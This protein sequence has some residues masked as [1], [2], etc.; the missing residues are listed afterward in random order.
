[1]SV[2]ELTKDAIIKFAAGFDWTRKM[3][4]WT[5]VIDGKEFPARPLLLAAAGVPPNDPTNSHMA[6]ARLKTLG[7]E[8]RYLGQ[9]A[10]AD[11]ERFDAEFMRM[12]VQYYVCGRWSARQG[13]MPVC[14]NFFHHAV[15]M[16]LKARLS[17]TYTTAELSQRPFAH[18]LLTLWAAF[19]SDVNVDEL[20]EFDPDITMLDRFESLRYP[21]GIVYRGAAIR[22][23]WKPMVPVP[24]LSEALRAHAST[25]PQYEIVVSRIDRLVKRIFEVSSRNPMFFAYD[26]RNQAGEALSYQN[27]EAAFW[28]PSESKSVS[29]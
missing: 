21:E 24:E 20:G 8:T 18:N 16:L 29:Q 13:H 2:D 23:S 25:V 3:P 22:T 19:K 1:M 14:G 28:F 6:V 9:K 17:R 10:N 15:E 4:K 27:E 12:G 26:F 11:P 7:F 5:V